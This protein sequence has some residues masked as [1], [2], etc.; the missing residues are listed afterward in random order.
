MKTKQKILV[1]LFVL[2]QIGLWLWC[3]NRNFDL[4]VDLANLR[5]QK[6]SLITTV[7]RQENQLARATSLQELTKMAGKLDIG[8]VE[9]FWQISKET[10]AWR[11]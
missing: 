3:R 7:D 8:L 11:Q 2:S 10:I 6:Q 1:L 9:H 5:C 4:A